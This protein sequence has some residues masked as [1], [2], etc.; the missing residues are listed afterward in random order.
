MRRGTV[1][2]AAIAG[3]ALGLSALLRASQG[4]LIVSA[5]GAVWFGASA[6][7]SA[8]RIRLMLALGLAASCCVLPVVLVEHE[9]STEWTPLSANGGMNFRIGNHRGASGTYDDAPFV[10]S[11]KGGDYRHTIVVERD[12]FLA[13]ARRRSGDARLTLARASEFWRNE[14]WQEIQADPTA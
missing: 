5:L 12:K 4:V 10:G 7:A 11:S 14:A 2:F 13:E 6:R 9:R 8:K 3:I 1:R